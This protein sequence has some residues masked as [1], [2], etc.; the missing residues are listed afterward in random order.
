VARDVFALF[1][2]LAFAGLWAAAPDLKPQL[3]HAMRGTYALYHLISFTFFCFP[4]QQIPG[5]RHAE[6]STSIV[7]SDLGLSPSEVHGAIQ[8]LR[9]SKL[10]HGPALKDKPNISALEEF[11]V[12]GLKYVFPAEHGEVMRGIPTSYAAATLKSEI[13]VSSDLPP[14]WSL[15]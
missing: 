7:A 4:C 11:L 2:L 13:A 12:H 6:K 3:Y 9:N 1:S 5:E 8:R 15:A 14:V 10:L